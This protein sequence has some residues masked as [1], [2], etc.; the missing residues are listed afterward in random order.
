MSNTEKKSE[1]HVAKNELPLQG[2]Q[3]VN[4]FTRELSDMVRSHLFK[5]MKLDKLKKEDNAHVWVMDV[6]AD[7]VVVEVS[8]Y[9]KAKTPS[10]T[11]SYHAVPYGRDTTGVLKLG[12]PVE[13]VRRV[14]YVPKTPAVQGVTKCEVS[15]SFWAG[16]L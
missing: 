6:F 14:T 3:S 13:V 9:E 16:V 11:S 4:A 5:S 15:K 8:K 7:N 12:A 10:H 2:G 1:I